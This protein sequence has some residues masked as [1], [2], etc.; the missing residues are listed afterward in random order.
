[1]TARRDSVVASVLRVAGELDALAIQ[2]A[3]R[4]KANADAAGLTGSHRAH[5]E[6]VF[7]AQWI[8]DGARQAAAQLRAVA[9]VHL[10]PK[11][12]Q[13]GRRMRQ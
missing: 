9:D 8:A 4:A 10:A 1:M 13:V 6:A 3:D 11:T 7:A 5:F 2:A 12:P